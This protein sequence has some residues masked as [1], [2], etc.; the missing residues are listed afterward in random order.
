MRLLF[1]LL[2]LILLFLFIFDTDLSVDPAILCE[3]VNERT[4]VML[5]LTLG[6]ER[7][8]NGLC[9]DEADE[10]LLVVPPSDRLILMESV[11]RFYIT[12]IDI[13]H[14]TN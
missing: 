4:S 10:P 14:C 11:R 6:F 12:T 13:D 3:P 7:A 1:K 9:D 8:E 5:L 2:E